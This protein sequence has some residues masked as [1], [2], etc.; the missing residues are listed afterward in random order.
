ME[1]GPAAM[2]NSIKV[3]HNNTF[4][5]LNRNSV[6]SPFRHFTGSAGNKIHH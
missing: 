1:I 6:A 5:I 4:T 2:R 3:K